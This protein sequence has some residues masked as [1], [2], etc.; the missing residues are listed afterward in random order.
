MGFNESFWVTVGTAAPV[1]A[2][3]A[4][5]AVTNAVRDLLRLDQGRLHVSFYMALLVLTINL[6]S[7]SPQTFVLLEALWSL[8]DHK[9]EIAPWF[10]I[11]FT[12]GGLGLLAVG[13]IA[14]VPFSTKLKLAGTQSKDKETET[15]GS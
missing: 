14:S 9:N 11:I 7:L 10:A 3:A 1:I 8:L 2:L 5:I 12:V 13:S 15:P 6:L 4:I